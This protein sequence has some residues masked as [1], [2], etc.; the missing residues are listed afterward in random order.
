[1]GLDG[2][3]WLGAGQSRHEVVVLNL[4]AGAVGG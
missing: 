3:G 4:W 2:K 1:M